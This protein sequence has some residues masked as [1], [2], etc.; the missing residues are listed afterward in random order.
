MRRYVAT[1]NVADHHTDAKRH[2]KDFG[3]PQN[4][5]RPNLARPLL[6]GSDVS[7][8]TRLVTR[9]LE[10]LATVALTPATVECAFATACAESTGHAPAAETLARAIIRKATKH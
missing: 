1:R 4:C 5:L 2:A 9:T 8:S 7:R 3:T 10:L 6:E